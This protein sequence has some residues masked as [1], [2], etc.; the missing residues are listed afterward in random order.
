MKR[1]SKCDQLKSHTEFHVR[2]ASNDGLAYKC[3]QCV[4]ANSVSWR[5]AHPTAHAEWYQANR[6]HKAAYFSEWRGQHKATEPARYAAWA[7]ANPDKVN[8]NIAKRSAAKRRAVPAWAN[9]EAVTKI[10][11]RAAALRR[12]TGRRYEVDH[13]VPLQGKTVCG[14]HWE[15]NLQ[16]LLKEDNISK[17]NR[18]WPDMP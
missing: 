12:S 4:N 6:A 9:L 2:R 17:L 13:I 18:R 11:A 7:K 5:A 8:A 15:G 16:I 1:C 3:R 10:Y 14:L